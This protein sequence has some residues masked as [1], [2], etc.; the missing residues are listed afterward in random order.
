[1]KE[2]L[3]LVLKQTEKS[4]GSIPSINK[5]EKLMYWG[6][7]LPNITQLRQSR[8]QNTKFSEISRLY[9]QLDHCFLWCTLIPNIHRVYS[10]KPIYVASVK[11]LLV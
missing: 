3:N 6:V 7:N 8:G 9:Y 5:R 1:M 2:I 11:S 10:H 4:S